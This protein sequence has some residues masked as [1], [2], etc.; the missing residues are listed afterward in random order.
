MPPRNRRTPGATLVDSIR[1]DLGDG[2]ELD[3]RDL[4]ILALVEATANDI[5]RLETAA[6][7]VLTD[8]GKLNPAMTEL[9]LARAQLARLVGSLKLTADE[10]P[11]P[12]SARH[13]YAANARWH[14]G[15]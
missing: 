5:A 14:R 8:S 9:R 6:E 7:Q 15:A 12:K 10:L 3:Q 11:A 2:I 13:Q 4:A 1:R